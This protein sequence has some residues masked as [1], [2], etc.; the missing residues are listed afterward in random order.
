MTYHLDP[1]SIDLDHVKG[2]I[3]GR[4][5]SPKR[6]ILG[7]KIDARFALLGSLGISSLAA[8]I[9]ATKTK[10]LLGELQARSG[11]PEE[12]LVV[13]GREA[14]GYLPKP[15]DLSR[16]PDIDPEL[17]GQLKAAGLGDSKKLWEWSNPEQIKPE[18]IQPEQISLEQIKPELAGPEWDS[19]VREL[20]EMADLARLPGVG[21]VFCRMLHLAGYRTCGELSQADAAEVDRRLREVNRGNRYTA[22]N[23]AAADLAACI[24]WAR[25]LADQ[26]QRH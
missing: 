2:E 5:L 15:I 26:K 6:R 17:L 24:R 23:A 3:A 19:A 1:D 8:L 20:A 13:L 7:E 25:R 12:Y 16:I 4:E 11:L 14:R 18:R 9:K 10:R 21:P 22:V